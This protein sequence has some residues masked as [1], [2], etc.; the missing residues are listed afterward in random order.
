M[1]WRIFKKVTD[2]TVAFYDRMCQRSI[3]AQFKTVGSG[4]RICQPFYGHGLECV[5]VGKNVTMGERTKIRA[6][7][8]WGAHNYSP[9]IKIADGVHICTDC[10]I[11]AVGEL[12]IGRDTLI[13]S[14]V[15]ISDLSH[16]DVTAEELDT[17]P[18]QRPLTS[19]G[20]ITIG[21]KVWIGEK[22]CILPGVT[23][24]DGAVIGSGA[25]VT[26]DI[27]ARAVAAGNPARVIR[28]L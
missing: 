19:K 25:V 11:S 9:N 21:S 22:V 16:G 7:A 3:A 20:P 26:K 28:Q 13:A 8:N 2:K 10:Q 27:P 23:I 17:P 12:T 1:I 6:Y 15:Y 24:G 5:E 4:L 14:F 18:L